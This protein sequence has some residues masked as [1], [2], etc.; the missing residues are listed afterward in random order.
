MT[1]EF[2]KYPFVPSSKTGS[3]F[4][5]NC[6]VTIQ[7]GRGPNLRQSQRWHL[8]GGQ[9]TNISSTP[10]VIWMHLSKQLVMSFDRQNDFL[11]ESMKSN[12]KKSSNQRIFPVTSV[13][14]SWSSQSSRTLRL[15]H[16]QHMA[17]LPCG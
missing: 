9:P 6:T 3:S 17:Q 10:P 7:A 11:N 1:L 2:P 16:L 15:W 4:T 14:Q 13:I 8:S 5:L 12:H